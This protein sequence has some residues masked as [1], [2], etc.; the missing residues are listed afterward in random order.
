MADNELKRRLAMMCDQCG[1]PLALAAR[2]IRSGKESFCS[3]QC[4][5]EYSPIEEE[6]NDDQ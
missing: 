4:A 3:Q 2:E 5:E 6:D 1:F